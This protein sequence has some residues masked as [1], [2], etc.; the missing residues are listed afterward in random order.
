MLYSALFTLDS[1][2]GLSKNRIQI[3]FVKKIIFLPLII[4][5]EPLSPL[6]LDKD[7]R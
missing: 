7:Q 2:V 6:Y 3:N 1:L 5:R 4:A